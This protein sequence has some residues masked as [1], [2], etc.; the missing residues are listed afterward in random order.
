MHSIVFSMDWNVKRA[1]TNLLIEAGSAT[2]DVEVKNTKFT[3][4]IRQ[5]SKKS[6]KILA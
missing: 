2:Q 6:N 3:F 5:V 4:Y 1:V